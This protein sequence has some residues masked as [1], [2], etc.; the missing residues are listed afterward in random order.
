MGKIF[1][2]RIARY[3]G[4]FDPPTLAR[5]TTETM[6]L[7]KIIDLNQQRCEKDCQILN[8]GGYAEFFSRPC[9]EKQGFKAVGAQTQAERKEGKVETMTKD[10]FL[11]RRWNNI[12][13]VGL[14]IPL[15]I[16]I[17]VT[18]ST[19]VLSEFASFLGMVIIGVVY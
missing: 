17:A 11:T 9:R 16:Y 5:E 10:A 13:A 7:K 3:C 14:G 4:I 6:F 12:L 18:L 2:S 19:S 1:H 8:L 15:L